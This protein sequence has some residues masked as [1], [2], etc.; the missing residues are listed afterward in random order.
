MTD[1]VRLVKGKLSW[2]LVI[3]P[4]MLRRTQE[5]NRHPAYY[6]I[7]PI[8][9]GKGCSPSTAP[10]DGVLGRSHQWVGVGRGFLDA[11]LVAVDC[12]TTVVA[13]FE[14]SLEGRSKIGPT[15]KVASSYRA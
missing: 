7:S 1:V 10:P 11:S 9:L 14:P 13:T 5:V 6:L 2:L 4:R 8:R 15:N 3:L 12:S